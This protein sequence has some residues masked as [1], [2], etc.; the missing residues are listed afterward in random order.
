VK[1]LICIAALVVTCLLAS[2]ECRA[3]IALSVS[4]TT[5]D[6][7][8]LSVGQT[9]S[10]DVK[11]SGLNAGDFIDYIPVTLNF[12]GTLLTLSG[13][14]PGAIIPD[15]GGFSSGPPV[16][17]PQAAIGLVTAQYD[18][19]NLNPPP[20]F[21]SPITSNGTFFSFSLVTQQAGQGTVSFD[22]T[23]LVGLIA[24]D[25]AGNP[26]GGTTGAD[27]SFNI[28]ASA[29]PTPEPATLIHLGTAAAVGLLCFSYR[30]LRS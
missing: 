2:W 19:L 22:S 4:S 12:D 7:N 18:D 5:P 13:L 1:R 30:M 17:T 8:N 21:F 26:L 6:L 27:V 24:S 15:T 9:V 25:V 28:V 11:V 23:S 14:N 29:I 16:I 20:T 3:D 10:F